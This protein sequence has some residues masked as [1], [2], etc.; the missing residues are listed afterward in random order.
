MKRDVCVGKPGRTQ[1]AVF[2][3][4]IQKRGVQILGISF[5]IFSKVQ[6]AKYILPKGPKVTLWVFE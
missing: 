5:F 3:P 2:D 4:K 6:M 1:S